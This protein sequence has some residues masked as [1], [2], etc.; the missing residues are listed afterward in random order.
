MPLLPTCLLRVSLELFAA[1]VSRMAKAFESDQHPAKCTVAT[2]SAA[3]P[4]SC[5]QVQQELFAAAVSL[6]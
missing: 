1:G 3:D 6:V 4:E 5:L 2:A